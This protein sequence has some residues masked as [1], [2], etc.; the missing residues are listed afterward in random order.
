MKVAIIGAGSGFGSRL[1]VDVLSRPPLEHSTI[2]LCDTDER[3]LKT[4]HAYVDKV[5]Q[6]NN[7]PAKVVSSTD[8]TEINT[9]NRILFP[10]VLLNIVITSMIVKCGCD[11]RDNHIVVMIPL[12]GF[13]LLFC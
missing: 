8:R 12:P 13:R 6:G 1:S 11:M 2:A 5:I 3:K 7:L 4:V 10:E 9:N